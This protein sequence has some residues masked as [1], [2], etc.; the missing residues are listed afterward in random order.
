MYAMYKHSLGDLEYKKNKRGNLYM[1][2]SQTSSWYP[3][4]YTRCK[5][6]G[7]TIIRSTKQSLKIFLKI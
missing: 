1:Y 5:S 3:E 4:K 7:D 6:F 2:L